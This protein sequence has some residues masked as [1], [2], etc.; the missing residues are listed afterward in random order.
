MPA[1][2]II[3]IAIAAYLLGSIPFGYLLVRTFRREDIRKTG[4]GNIGATNV[5]RSGAKY[6][7][8]LTFLLDALKGA[9][10][11]IAARE[12]AI[13]SLPTW[14]P[15]GQLAWQHLANR[16]AIATA[17]AGVAA[18]L[19]H[20][21]PIWLG[22]KGG[23]GVATAFGVLA[24]LAPQAALVALTVFL[25]TVL[26]SRY[27]SLASILGC[28]AAPIAAA[29]LAPRLTG[30]PLTHTPWLLAALLII[31]AIVIA[32]HHANIRRLLDGSE[33][34]FGRSKP[35]AA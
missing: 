30:Q 23:K 1:F 31:P 22:F 33:Y 4:S 13:L 21:Y 3:L 10:A 18:V 17:I 19:G 14:P 26:L 15:I 6:L 16:L 32:K 27:V 20:I 11:I 12:L 24:Q 7:G 34:R 9:L 8:A 2:T 25:L 29:I 35:A 28:L 5:V